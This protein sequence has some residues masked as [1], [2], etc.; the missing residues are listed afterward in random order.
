MEFLDGQM[1]KDSIADRPL[2]LAQILDLGAEITDGLE[3]AHQLGIVHRDIKSAN[4]FVTK[5]GRVKILDFGLIRDLVVPRI[6]VANSFSL[7]V[8]EHAHPLG[9]AQ[10]GYTPCKPGTK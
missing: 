3:A 8:L 4:I 9:Q 2:S 10:T 1:L 7:P 5:R 6:L